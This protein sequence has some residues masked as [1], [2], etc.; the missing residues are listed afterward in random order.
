MLNS[1]TYF[2]KIILNSL[3]SVLLICLQHK[4]NSLSILTAFFLVST[5]IPT[6]LISIYAEPRYIKSF[7][8]KLFITFMLLIEYLLFFLF[9]RFFDRCKFVNYLMM[10]HFI[11]GMFVSC[12]H[13]FLNEAVK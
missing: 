7:R 9:Y 6:L 1:Y 3:C 13:Y 4:R 5:H 10:I 2:A 11:V 8:H 12:L